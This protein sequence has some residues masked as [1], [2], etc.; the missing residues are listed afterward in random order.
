MSHPH[1]FLLKQ[2][3]YAMEH[4]VPTVPESVQEEAKGLY[5]RLLAN[6]LATEEEVL[7]ALAKVGKGEYPH[8]HAFWDLTKKAGEVKR[9]E[10]ILDHLDVSVRSKLEELL[11]TGANLEEIVRSSL[12][13][14]RFNPEERY[15]IQDG[16]LDA[17]EHMKDD[18]VDIIK[19]HQAEYE[20]LVSQYEVYMDEI[21]K[22]IDILRSLANKDPKWRDEILDKVRTLEAGWSVTE[23]D[24]ELEIVKKEIEYWRG[25]LGEEE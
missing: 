16:I 6:E 8:R 10:I 15:Q 7:A 11:E 13:E 2:F 5:D 20:K 22:Q 24:P 18:M 4:F 9:I 17:D 1:Q 21:Q 25:T 23:R 12:F 14:E 3:K 19:E